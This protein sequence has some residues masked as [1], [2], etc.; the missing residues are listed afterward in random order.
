MAGEAFSVDVFECRGTP[1]EV[2]RQMAEGYRRTRRENARAPQGDARIATF[3]LADARHLLLAHAPNL[4]EELH[5]IADGLQMPLKE[6]VARFS[7][8]RL[9]YP[10]R[11]CSAAIGGGLYGRNYDFSP[12]RYDRALVA[13]QAEGSY[14]HLGLADR[15]TGR[16]D[17]MNEHGLC[18][19]LHYV[20]E[21]APRPGLVCILVVRIVLDRCA[22]TAE[23]V[24]LLSRLPHGLMFNYSLLDRVGEAAVIEASPE[25]V[26]VHRGVP[27]ACTNHFRSAGLETAN[28]PGAEESRRRLPPLE[29]MAAAR[30]DAAGLFHALN[31]GRSPAF[32]HGYAGGFGT[33]HTIVCNPADGTVLIGI[34]ADATPQCFDLAGWVRGRALG[35]GALQG[36]IGT[37]EDRRFVGRDLSGAEFRNVSLAAAHFDDINFAGAEITANCNFRGMRIAGVSIEELFAAYRRTRSAPHD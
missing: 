10:R 22:S 6:A 27:I 33:L 37:A 3:D 28:G 24:D 20:S 29:A 36:R 32:R 12:A 16:L 15:Y 2:G 26:A 30:L 7:N 13:V 23:A 34:G 25:S 17:G 21:A 1:Y 31:N 35:I 5:G 19:G 4:W 14:A 9:A 18:V 11:G 8:G